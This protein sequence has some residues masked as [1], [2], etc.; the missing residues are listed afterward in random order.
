[1]SLDDHERFLMF[2]SHLPHLIAYTTM[3]SID[4]EVDISKFS[5][6]GLKEFLR[7]AESNPDLW[8][9]IFSS[10]SKNLKVGS[11]IFIK[12]LYRIIDLFEDPET[13]KE[14]LAEIR[15]KKQKL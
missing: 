1:M 13:L 3:L 14:L 9:D 10:N 4:D 2:T 15:N 8:A 6:G 11:E 5:A 7:I 12:N